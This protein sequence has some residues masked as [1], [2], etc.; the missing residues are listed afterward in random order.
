MWF[1]LAL[2][3]FEIG[4]AI[5][6]KFSFRPVSVQVHDKLP[7]GWQMLV[8]L[9]ICGM[10]AFLLRIIYP[11]GGKN[12]I[13]LQFGYFVLYTAFYILG[14]SAGRNKWLERFEFSQSIPWGFSALFFIP[15]ILLAWVDV[16]HHPDNISMYIGGL[17][18]K[19]LLLALWESMVC[20][21]LSFFLI[22]LFR[23]K[24]N[25]GTAATLALARD[26]YTAYIIHPLIVVA[27]TILFEPLPLSPI[28]K[29]MIAAVI[30]VILTYLL[31]H[32]IRTFPGAR[33]I[34]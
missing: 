3:I 13:G 32:V 30:I 11:I 19:S 15:F 22:L 10:L 34:L 24:F 16:T 28:P 29:F 7:T 5:Y 18:F 12:F 9:L 23:E 31:A 33:S 14:I 27:I 1:V 25:V 2:L 8:F 4:Y 21:S 6:Q 20:L 17:H 26:S